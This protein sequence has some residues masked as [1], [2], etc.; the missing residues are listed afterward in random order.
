MVSHLDSAILCL[1]RL[2]APLKTLFKDWKLKD[3]KVI[4]M[5]SIKIREIVVF[6]VAQNGDLALF[7]G[8]KYRR[9]VGNTHKC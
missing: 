4:K 3:F 5:L 1:F 6:L 9:L 8:K 7:A 2:Y